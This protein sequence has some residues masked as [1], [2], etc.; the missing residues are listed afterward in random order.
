MRTIFHWELIAACP[1]PSRQVSS[2]SDPNS[3]ILITIMINYGTKLISI[4]IDIVSN[5]I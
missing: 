2:D 3:A 5:R 4:M 1:L